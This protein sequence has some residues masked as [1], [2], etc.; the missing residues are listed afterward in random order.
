M[1]IQATKFE[2]GKFWMLFWLMD[3]VDE[4]ERTVT[5]RLNGMAKFLPTEMCFCRAALFFHD[6]ATRN[7][8]SKMTSR[9]GYIVVSMT[10]G[11]KPNLR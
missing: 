2:S 8:D 10:E 1:V 3:A 6:G 7:K 11:Y 4:H 5:R 9:S